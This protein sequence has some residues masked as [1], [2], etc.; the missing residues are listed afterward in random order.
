MS[1]HLEPVTCGPEGAVIRDGGATVRIPG[2]PVEAVDT[3]GAGDVFHGA[4]LVALALGLGLAERLRLAGAA[5][6]LA[7]T[8]PGAR[9]GIPPLEQA[10]S[11][12]GLST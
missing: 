4:Y 9:T 3:N 2:F 5:A 1:A 8:C 10:L 7:C 12:A 11:A 6:G